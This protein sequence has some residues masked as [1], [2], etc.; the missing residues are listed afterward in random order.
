MMCHFHCLLM[1][2]STDVTDVIQLFIQGGNVIFKWL[3]TESAWTFYVEKLQ[4]RLFCENLN[5]QFI[6]IYSNM[7]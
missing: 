3:K 2:Q 4:V 1:S 6:T 5:K 7:L